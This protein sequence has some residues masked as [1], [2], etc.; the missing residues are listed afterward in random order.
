MGVSEFL[1]F[2]NLFVGEALV[3]QSNLF[4]LDL[5]FVAHLNILLLF[6]ILVFILESLSISLCEA[7]NINVSLV[8]RSNCSHGGIESPGASSVDADYFY[9][10]SWFDLI[11]HIFISAETN[12]EWG[13]SF[14]NG[15]WGF[16]HLDV[17]LV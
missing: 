7:N 1:E 17:L 9:S 3:I 13:L 10:V 16:L 8:N 2:S 5:F 11:Y 14:R 4:F 15:I 12:V 6:V